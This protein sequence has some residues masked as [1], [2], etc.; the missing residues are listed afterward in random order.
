MNTQLV[1]ISILITVTRPFSHYY[2]MYSRDLFSPYTSNYEAFITTSRN[3]F[4]GRKNGSNT[5]K[6]GILDQLFGG[7]KVEKK[8]KMLDQ[9]SMFK[10]AQQ[11]AQ[12]KDAIDKELA[13]L[14]IVGKA[15][16]GRIHVTIRYL[17]P[18]MPTSPSPGYDTIAVNIDDEYFKV[19]PC[20]ELSRALENAIRD[21]ETKANNIV[22][23]KYRALDS[24]MGNFLGDSSSKE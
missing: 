3:L 5:D 4:G 23:K 16:D 10:K 20:D 22:A 13:K 2:L 14:D 18:C 9:L 15:A 11:I 6:E 7:K 1:I 19:V 12:K 24:D 17:P 21:G 8:S